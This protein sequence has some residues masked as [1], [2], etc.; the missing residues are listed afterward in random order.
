MAK[1][2][3][4]V[5]AQLDTNPAEDAIRY[6][7]GVGDHWHTATGLQALAV[8]QPQSARCAR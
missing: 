3:A 8:M 2:Y 5:R 6:F 4:T 1:G 7:R